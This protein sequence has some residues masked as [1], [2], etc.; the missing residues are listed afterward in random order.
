MSSSIYIAIPVMVLLGLLQTAVMPYFAI[1]DLSPQ[2]PLL[3]AMSW[4]FL[5]TIDEGVQWAF[6]A[7]LAVDFFSLT[8]LGVS[9]VS[10]MVAVTAVVWIQKEFP[11]SHFLL[12]PLLAAVATV[13][14]LLCDLILLRLFGILSNFQA[15]VTLWPLILLN[16][17]VVLPIYWLTYGFNRLAQLRHRQI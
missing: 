3:L 5:R 7:G 11:P 14:F 8:P 12:P 17:A 13:I 6:V 9:A 10:Y 4:G 15:A 1:A 16:T 2:L